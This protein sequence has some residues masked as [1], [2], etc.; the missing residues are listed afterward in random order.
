MYIQDPKTSRWLWDIRER[1]RQQKRTENFREIMRMQQLLA[2]SLAE[3]DE[4][5]DSAATREKLE[6]SLGSARNAFYDFRQ[7]LLEKRKRS[8][9]NRPRGASSRCSGSA[10]SRH[11]LQSSFTPSW[12]TFLISTVQRSCLRNKTVASH[13]VIGIEI[14]MA[15]TAKSRVSKPKPLLNI[16]LL[17]VKK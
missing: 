5:D 9:L 12:P 16:P 17:A 11:K 10:G 3:I 8:K 4:E 2:D 15:N 14:A 13:S 1:V 7:N 6:M